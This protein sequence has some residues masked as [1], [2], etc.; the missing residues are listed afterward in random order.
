M[1]SFCSTVLGSSGFSCGLRLT[2]ERDEARS[3]LENAVAVARA[4]APGDLANGK[5]AT[6]AEG[7]EEQPAKR[8]CPSA[9][10]LRT[11]NFMN[12]EALAA[13]CL[14]HALTSGLL[15]TFFRQASIAV[16]TQQRCR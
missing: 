16:N 4:A 14:L 1:R 11:T 8:V 13:T 10:L 9:I 5:R 2:R 7:E 3:Q 6:E 12:S 15:G